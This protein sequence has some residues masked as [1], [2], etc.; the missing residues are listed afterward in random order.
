MWEDGE[1][2][3]GEVAVVVCCKGYIH[4]CCLNS[5]EASRSP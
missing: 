1:G 3:H 5:V 2:E 4:V